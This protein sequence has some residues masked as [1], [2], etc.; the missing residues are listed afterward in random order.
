MRLFIEA[1][2]IAKEK[3]SGIGHATLEM[4]RVLDK[5][6][7]RLS[8]KVTVIV[9][10]GRK[11]YV[12]NRY[13]FQHIT[14]RQLPPGY[15]YVNYALTRT[16]LPIPVD[17]WYGRGTYIFPNY[18]NWYV[19]FSQ[20]IMFIHDVAY[21]LFPET[22]HPK[23]LVYLRANFDRWVKRTNKAVSISKQ[24][25]GE[26]LQTFPALKGR[27]ATI[28]LGIDPT[29]FNPRSAEEITHARQKYGVG[30]DYFLVVGSIEPRKNIAKLVEAYKTYADSATSP[31]Q[32]IL[33]GGDGWKSDD[34]LR[35]IDDLAK[36]GYRIYRPKNYVADEDLPALYSGAR[37]V[38]SVPI[39]EGFGLSPVQA[40]G[41][42]VPVIV[43]DIPVF[44]EII[45]PED[46][47]YVD[48]GSEEAMT[49]A[50]AAT[51]PVVAR[52]QSLAKPELT[53]DNTVHELLLF[54][55]IIKG[56]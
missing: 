21:K 31:A 15:K 35:R 37:A 36:D 47:S 24:S 26:V 46:A 49:D 41:C 6:V 18:K 3:M 34:L 53:W 43:S 11:K 40:Q 39:H 20:S 19:P 51:R 9:P 7:L 54:A 56:Q 14:I 55:G 48:P 42:G 32:L 44:R 13:Q 1:D 52:R 2:S 28:Y 50:L 23:N 17:L 5:Q 4:L 16:S 29:V 30:D 22:T 38:V 25:T 8:L 27:I 33:V 12:Q 10:F 45:T